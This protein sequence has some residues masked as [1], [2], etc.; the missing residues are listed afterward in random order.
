MVRPDTFKSYL[1]EIGR[2]KL[3][4]PEEEVTYGR[5]VADYMALRSLKNDAE[6]ARGEEISE[7]EWATIVNTTVSELRDR[8]KI[9]KHAHD[10]MTKANLRLVVDVAKKYQ[11]RGL[12]LLDLVQEGSIG[13]MRAVEKFD[14][15]KGYKFSTYAYWWIRQAVTRAIA[16]D[17]RIIRLPIHISEKLSRVKK[18]QREL[19]QELGRLATKAEVAEALG[20]KVDALQKLIQWNKKMISLSMLVGDRNGSKDTELIEVLADE[21]I[22][23]DVYQDMVIDEI[24][25]KLLSVFDTSNRSQALEAF[26][27][28]M[29]FGLDGSD[30]MTL[31]QVADRLQFSRERAR[32]IE[33][34]ALQ[35]L[36]SSIIFDDRLDGIRDQY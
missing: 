23:E 30:R 25:V 19:S 10:R 26:V 1:Q 31:K 28:R 36:R 32:Q 17:S 24:R 27:L 20:I 3:L 16:Q 9:G 18:V 6:A 22:E 35:R 13:L 21:K 14:S 12:D 8:L 7:E 34:K 29:R 11:H 2:V 33:T 15:T 5:Q 4:T